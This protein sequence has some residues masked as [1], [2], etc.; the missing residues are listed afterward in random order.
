[1]KSLFIAL[2]SFYQIIIS[3][4]LH[5]L[6]GVKNMC[7]YEVSCSEY[8]KRVI[9]KHGVLKGSVL[10]IKRLLSCQPFNSSIRYQV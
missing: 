6:L 7:R 2:V 4:L 8:A 5:Q 3:P 10:A 1:M 9:R